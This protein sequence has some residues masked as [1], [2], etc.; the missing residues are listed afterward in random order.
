ML[1]SSS[2]GSQRRINEGR[3]GPLSAPL[4][5]RLLIRSAVCTNHWNSER[6]TF[7][8]AFGD[9][10]TPQRLRSIAASPK[11]VEGRGFGLRGVP[12]IAVHSRSTRPLVVDHAP[13]GRGAASERMGEQIDQR[14]D[15][16][17][18]ARLS[19]LHD[20]RLEP[21]H[22]APDFLPVD[23]VPVR[24][25]VGS[26]TSKRCRRR[27]IC[28]SPRVGSPKL[29][30]DRRLEGSQH[31]CG[32]GDV[33]GWLN[34]YPSDYQPAFACSLIP[35]PQPHRLTLRL[36]VLN[37]LGRL[38]GEATGL[39]RS[40]LVAVW[41]RSRLF[42]GGAT[43]APGDKITPGPDHVPFWPQR[44]SILRWLDMTTFSSA[45]PGLTIPHVPGARLRDAGSRERDSHPASPSRRM[46]LR[47]PGSFRPRSCLQRRSQKETA[48]RTA[49]VIAAPPRDTTTS[50][51]FVSHILNITFCPTIARDAIRWR[52]F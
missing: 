38:S 12:D 36:A 13:D 37:N 49:G 1:A 42:A 50:D 4:S 31:P 39:P 28:L 30:R 47:Y 24:R 34:P 9:V 2:E 52:H 45:S 29:S 22:G 48:G 25:L 15:L 26:R 44:L 40:L 16:I 5:P 11:L 21:T 23:G 20:T 17:P 6:S 35:Y 3:T 41:V 18:S 51:D 43:S 14:A 33:A 10:H 46:R 27:H 7:A 19:R 32:W 8:I